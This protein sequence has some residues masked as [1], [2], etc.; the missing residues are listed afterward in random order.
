VKDIV[1]VIVFLMVFT[2][3]LF[4]AP[5]MG[6]TSL[7]PTTSSRRP[8][9][10]RSHRAAVVLHPVLRDPACGAALFGS[11]FPGVVAMACRSS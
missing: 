1:G 4:F 7:K 6:A 9:K 10:T 3:I 8:L 11:Q 5:E 2:A